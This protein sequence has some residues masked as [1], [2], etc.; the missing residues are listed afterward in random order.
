MDV[1]HFSTLNRTSRAG[2]ANAF[3]SALL[4]LIYTPSLL[5]AVEI[6]TIDA[7]DVV[8]QKINPLQRE[9]ATIRFNTSNTGQ[10]ILR[11]FD[12]KGF[13]VKE[14]ALEQLIPDQPNEVI[15]DGRDD[16]GRIVPSEAYSFTIEAIDNQENVAEY[17]PE[18]DANVNYSAF[19]PRF[20]EGK[21]RLEFIL[22]QDAVVDIR[23]GVGDGG[24]MLVKLI[25]W[26]PM[27]K[28]EHYLE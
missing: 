19:T 21:Q 27:L 3:L 20:N 4:C 8:P 28:G 15:W 1:V 16:E 9:T 14:Y 11:I 26:Q 5:A 13:Q 6:S 2:F 10:A 7:V 23:A 17:S 22:D 18:V 12:R 24:P 25:E